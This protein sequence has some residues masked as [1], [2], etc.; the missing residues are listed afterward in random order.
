MRRSQA[1]TASWSFLRTF[2]ARLTEVKDR[3]GSAP[4]WEWLK[5]F[6]RPPTA[7]LPQPSWAPVRQLIERTQQSWTLRCAELSELGRWW[8]GALHELGGDPSTRDWSRFRPLRLSREE[9]FSDW[10]AH[11]LEASRSGFFATRLFGLAQGD[12][13]CEPVVD[14]EVTTLDGDR[15][16]DILVRWRGNAVTHIEVKLDD[17]CYAKTFETAIQLQDNERDSVWTH[18]LLLPD[19]HGPDWR[20]VQSDHP[21]GDQV[22]IE[23]LSWTAV[24]IALRSAL[25]AGGEPGSW[26]AWAWALCGAVEQ[27]ILRHP[28]LDV[29]TLRPVEEN[30]GVAIENQIRVMRKARADE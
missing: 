24:A 10:L 20:Q 5:T 12:Q 17:H 7:A 13:A 22:H 15:R 21:L 27:K 1:G 28:R 26:R 16:A 8:H 19:E 18:Y 11:L 29:E 2:N 23:E 25:K 30:L 9:D 3:C 14:R 6:R 4:S